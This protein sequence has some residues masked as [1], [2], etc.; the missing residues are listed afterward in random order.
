MTCRVGLIGCGAMALGAYL[1]ALSQLSSLYTVVAVADPSRERRDLAGDAFGISNGARFESGYD[2]LAVDLDA[3]LIITPPQV[4]PDFAVAA[5][6][7]GKNVL[8]EKPLATRPADAARAVHA[9]AGSDVRLG[10]SHNYLWFPEYVAAREVIASGAIGAV[11]VVQINALGVRD[12]PGAAGTGAACNWRYDPDAGGGG[13]LMDMLHLVYIAES[14]CGSAFE[15]ISGYVSS[16]RPGSRVETI[17]LC[18]LETDRNA[19]L[20]NVGW[21]LGGGGTTVSGSRGRLEIRYQD[22]GTSPFSPLSSVTVTTAEGTT[23]VPTAPGGE[24]IADVLTDFA[25]SVAER[26]PPRADGQAGLRILEAVMAVYASA[27]RGA[28]IVLPLDSADPVYLR[29]VA[30]LAELP[31]SRSSPVVRQKLFR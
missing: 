24:T 9:A 28:S 21:G 10:V 19:A 13:V 8:C 5:A 20:V 6:H 3:V 30:G 31:A 29:G 16:Y 17:A 11:E 2:L 18:R 4:R 14:L 23:T 22:G 27:T 25:H 26:R 12:N 7:A 1:P 15:I